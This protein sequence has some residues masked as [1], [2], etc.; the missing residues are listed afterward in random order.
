MKEYLCY[1]KIILSNLFSV[2]KSGREIIAKIEVFNVNNIGQVDVTVD[3]YITDME[4]NTITQGSD[5]LAV[6]AVASF[7]RILTV[8]YSLK[9]GKYLFNV[10]IRYKDNL[11][12]SGHAEF[13]VIKSYWIIIVISVVALIVAGIFFYLWRI[14]KK[15]EKLEKKE[16]RLEKIVGKLKNKNK[17]RKK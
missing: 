16:A 1:F 4:N 10:E 12:A 2:V 9:S 7:V 8:P 5:T 13:R 6:E 14:G 17:R 3:Y 15:G 11:M